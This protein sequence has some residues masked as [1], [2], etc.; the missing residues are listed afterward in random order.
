MVSG[1]V[2]RFIVVK[3]ASGTG[4]VELDELELLEELE[5][6]AVLPL[7]EFEDVDEAVLSSVALALPTPLVALA[8]SRELELLLELEE[9]ELEDDCK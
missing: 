9:E 4:A 6:V 5:L 3:A 1:D 7:E 2:V 8:V